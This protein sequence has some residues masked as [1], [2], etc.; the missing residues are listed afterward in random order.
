MVAS[1]M[2][3]DMMAALAVPLTIFASWAFME[4][5]RQLTMKAREEEKVN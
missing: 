1:G 4:R 5:V 3:A 2:T